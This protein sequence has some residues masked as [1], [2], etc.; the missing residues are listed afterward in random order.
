[1][2][3]RLREVNRAGATQILF[4][5]YFTPQERTKPARQ[6]SKKHQNIFLTSRVVLKSGKNFFRVHM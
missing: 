4:L 1:V 5:M 3:E 2:S 6:R